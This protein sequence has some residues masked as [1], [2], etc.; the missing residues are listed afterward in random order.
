MCIPRKC[1]SRAALLTADIDS[2]NTDKR[3]EE[4]VETLADVIVEWNTTKQYK[5]RSTNKEI[6]GNC[7]GITCGNYC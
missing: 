3:V 1:V 4:V 2:I 6:E 5:D 7:Q